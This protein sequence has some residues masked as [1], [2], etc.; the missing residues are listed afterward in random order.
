[1]DTI[2]PWRKTTLQ[3]VSLEA[4][5]TVLE[6]SRK[7]DSVDGEQLHQVGGHGAWDK[8]QAMQLNKEGLVLKP[9]QKGERGKKEVAFYEDISSSSDP[10]SVRSAFSEL[11]PHYFGV[12]KKLM[13]DGSTGEF[14]MMENLTKGFKL[15]CVMDIKMGARTW[16]PDA[17]AEKQSKQDSSYRGTK[18][19]FG[20]SVPGLNVFLDTVFQDEEKPEQVVHGKEFGRELG[21]ETIDSLI[22]LYLGTETREHAAR[23]LAKI[24]LEKLHPIQS[25]FQSQTTYNL[26]GSSLLFVY[27]AAACD[28]I[29][30]ARIRNSVCLKMIDFAHVWPAEGKLD[31]NYLHGVDNLIKLF[32]KVL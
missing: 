6:E 18:I 28:E 19:P 9:V 12:S 31:T 17:D 8:A 5:K 22:P 15:P 3:I 23:L 25:L 13:E 11:M 32:E 14:L 30:E 21:E 10:S 1:M 7:E 16:A 27:D 29:D 26:Y 4:W 20:F 2:R 24:F